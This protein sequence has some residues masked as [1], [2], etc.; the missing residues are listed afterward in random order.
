VKKNLQSPKLEPLNSKRTTGRYCSWL[1]TLR[2]APQRVNT[3]PVIS[4]SRAKPFKKMTAIETSRDTNA[5]EFR[6]VPAFFETDW[7]YISSQQ[8]SKQDRILPFDSLIP[9]AS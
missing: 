4:C 5:P 2:F 6:E 9:G 3:M 1:D 7:L 8:E